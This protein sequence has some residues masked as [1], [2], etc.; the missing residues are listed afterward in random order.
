[1]QLTTLFPIAGTPESINGSPLCDYANDQ[2][3]CDTTA[4]G[5]GAWFV[6]SAR[7]DKVAGAQRYDR[8]ADENPWAQSPG[9]SL[10]AS[11][12]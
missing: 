12:A 2:K 8:E 10:F 6:L 5:G 1:M 11:M 7:G 9:V 4:E 3:T